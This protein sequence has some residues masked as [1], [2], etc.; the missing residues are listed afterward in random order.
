MSIQNIANIFENLNTCTLWSLQLLKI[1]A[2]KNGV[3]YSSREIELSSAERLTKLIKD[4]AEIYI[5]GHKKALSLY[6]DIMEYDGT[7]NA[8][9]IY[10][11]ST[12]NALIANE[13]ESLVAA[14]ANP[15]I[16]GDSFKYT[17][18]Y[19]IKGVVNLD[20]AAIPVKMFS[21]QNPI[22]TLKN[23]FLQDKGKF[24]EISNQVLHLRPTVDVIVID[25]T[26]Y[27]LTMAGENLFNMARAY[28]KV[29]Q[30]KVDL[31]IQNDILN[32]AKAFSDIAGSG[33]NPRRFVSF[34]EERLNLLTNKTTRHSIADQFLIPLDSG[35]KFDTT[36]E[37]AS[38]KIVKLLCNKGM[39]DPF[40][41]YAVEV[42]GARQ[43]K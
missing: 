14:I 20:G 3:H 36:V 16:E 25:K 4:I 26:I 19:L 5:N 15:D 1:T 31:V 40:Y 17:S 28:K 2:N 7:A 38:E 29:C 42:D 9:T 11:M 35:G 18:A 34:K 12:D 37:G 33:H 39:I 23:K 24:C 32:D 8:L 43:W 27:F 30:V 41:N 22:T 10:K 13:Y 21:I 6:Q